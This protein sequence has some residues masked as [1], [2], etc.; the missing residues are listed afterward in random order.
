MEK[1]TK[2]TNKIAIRDIPYSLKKG[3]ILYD[4]PHKREP[5]ELEFAEILIHFGSDIIFI[6]PSIM[7]GTNTPDCEWRD[8]T[9]ETKIAIV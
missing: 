5:H 6:K 8:K 7:T 9:W 3:K 1:K 4:Y 2:K